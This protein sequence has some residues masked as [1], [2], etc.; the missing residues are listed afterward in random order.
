MFMLC[1][2]AGIAWMY[3]CCAPYAWDVAPP[4][5]VPGKLNGGG[6]PEWKG[7]LSYDWIYDFEEG[8]ENAKKKKTIENCPN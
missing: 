2:A 3:N 7:C 4:V 1:K 6:V 8:D 5:C